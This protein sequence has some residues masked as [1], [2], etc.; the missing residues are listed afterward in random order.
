MAGQRIA[1]GVL[2]RFPPFYENAPSG[3]APEGFDADLMAEIS[4]TTGLSFAWRRYETFAA[5]QAALQRGEVRIVTA[6]AQTA[7]RSRLMRFTR[8]Y[9][10]VQQGIVGPAQVT[11]VPATPDL[12]GRRLAVIAGFASET[13][14][15]ERFP[16]ATRLSYPTL[17]AHSPPWPRARPT[18]CSKPCPPCAP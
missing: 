10:A 5:L 2:G 6:V 15:S 8:P 9:A 12:S 14:A 3:Q 4:A 11:S 13:I 18:L 17:E 16:D 1:V 7:S